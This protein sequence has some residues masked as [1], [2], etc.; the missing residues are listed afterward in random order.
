MKTIYRAITKGLGAGVLLTLLVTQASAGCGDLSNYQGPFKIVQRGGLGLISPATATA[1][2]SDSGGSEASIVGMWKIQ[3]IAAG[4]SARNPPIPDGA[5]ID[6]GYTQ[7]H[8][9]GT[10]ILN[11]GAH[12]PSTQNF[13]L[14]VWGKTGFLA[15]ELNHFALSYDSLTG[16]LMN[17]VNI[18][19]QLTLSPS[20]DMYTG[21]FTIDVYDTN[22]NHV[23]HIA[24]NIT[25]TRITVDSTVF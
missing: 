19:E 25:A 13:C 18:R 6:F 17:Y 24:G 12:S 7:L 8:S 3:F 9:D 10:E 21:T 23:D 20:G 11:S 4:N 16:G 5:V 15:Y 14:G 22:Q 1:K 2:A